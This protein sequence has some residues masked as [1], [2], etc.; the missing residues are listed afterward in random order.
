MPQTAEEQFIVGPSWFLLKAMGELPYTLVEQDQTLL[1]SEEHWGNA[2]AF[3]CS[4]C[5]ALWL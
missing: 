2:A 1:H 5:W 4:V 3:G